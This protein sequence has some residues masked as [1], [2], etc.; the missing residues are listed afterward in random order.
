MKLFISSLAFSCF[1]LPV[2]NA[3]IAS[4]GGVA[5]HN[6][7]AN[8]AIAEIWNRTVFLGAG[9]GTY[10]GKDASGTRWVLTADHVS[11]GSGTIA[12]SNN[13]EIS[14]TYSG[15][16][17]TM[18]N[19]DGSIAD[20]KLFSVTATGE[21]AEYLDALGNLDIYTGTLPTSSPLYCVGTGQNLSIGSAIAPGTART[22]QW[23]EFSFVGKVGKPVAD[24]GRKSDVYMTRFSREFDSFQ[25][26]MQDSGSGIFVENAGNW[27]I[28]GIAITVGVN[29]ST[30]EEAQNAKVGYFEDKNTV[31]ATYFVNLSAYAPQIYAIIPEPSA[32]GLFAGLASLVF[33]ATRRRRKR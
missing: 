7:S 8:D 2:A 21:N 27:E 15:T 31:C 9:T 20:L 18:K 12:T 24:V 14:L 1:V 4:V 33:V 13:Q 28:A 32:F 6:T 3:M 16:A 10:L 5:T 29:S 30:N 17:H 25:A 19:S 26:G 23:A 22:K 11:S